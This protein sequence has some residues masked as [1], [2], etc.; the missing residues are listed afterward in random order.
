MY[1]FAERLSRMRTE[2]AFAI[3]AKANALEAEGKSIVHLEIGQPDFPT[4][5]HIV[6][7]GC[8]AL[9]DG[10]TRYGP[11]SGL[12]DLKEAIAEHISESR[13]IEVH[14]DEVV[15]TPGAK[16][17]IFFTALAFL[18][19]GD[20]MVYADPGF[21]IYDSVAAMA[22]AKP[23]PVPI[24]EE[25]DFVLK[26]EDFA[27]RVTDRTKLLLINSPQNPTGGVLAREDIEA[28]AKIA[29]ERQIMVLSDEVYSRILYE[30]EHVSFASIPGMRDLTILLVEL[31]H[32]ELHPE[33]R[34]GGT[35]GA[36]GLCWRDGRGVRSAEE[37]H[38]RQHKL[39]PG[40]VVQDAEGRLLPVLQREGAGHGRRRAAEAP[41]RRGRRSDDARHG[42]RAIRRGLHARVI[43]NEHRD[44]RRGC[45]PYQALDGR[46]RHR[47]RMRTRRFVD[48]AGRSERIGTV[49]D[50]D[51]GRRQAGRAGKA[52]H[53]GERRRRA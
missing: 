43:C 30:G 27:D 48:D 15:V 7:A 21:P 23:V 45:Q 19:E 42:L 10:H 52:R 29:M 18:E 20:E 34:C 17:I 31:V 37:I 26:A 33:G 3:L 9:R 5:E 47:H 1:D 36:T 49:R 14:P 28:I 41:T 25:N 4:P 53:R 2:G 16:P 32:G 8:K 46:C 6:E 51:D 40:L 50:D 39:P 24:R 44:P 35:P 38:R 12:P 22:G 11:A 13:G